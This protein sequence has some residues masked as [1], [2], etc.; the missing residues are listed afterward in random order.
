KRK[1]IEDARARGEK[2]TPVVLDKQIMGR[3]RSEAA[4]RAVE[5]VEAAGGT[6]HYH[7]VNLMDG[8]AVAAVVEDIRSRYGKIDV[9]LHA[10]GLLIDR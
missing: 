10:G 3:E 5:A 7:A 4:L 9:L 6:A 1:L 2:P 8:D